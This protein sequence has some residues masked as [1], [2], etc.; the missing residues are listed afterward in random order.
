MSKPAILAV[1]DDPGVSRAIARDLRARYGAD[2]QVIRA[3]SG[4]RR[5]TRWGSWRCVTAPWPSWSPTSGC[6]G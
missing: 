1:D 6:R 2:Y 3:T 5:S 4:A